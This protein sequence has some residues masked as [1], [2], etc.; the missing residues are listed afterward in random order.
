MATVIGLCG[1]IG[2]GKTTV[3]NYLV[4]EYGF[5][6]RALAK[7]LKD[8]TKIIFQLSDSQ[9]KD[10]E[11]R[12]VVDPRWDKTPRQLMQLFGTEVG[13]SIDKNVW[14]K[15]L[16]SWVDS[17]PDNAFVVV[18]DVRFLNEAKTIKERGGVV[19][20]VRREKCIPPTQ[21]GDVFPSVV[22]KTLRLPRTHESEKQMRNYFHKMTDYVI[23]NET[24]LNKLYDRV[25]FTLSQLVMEGKIEKLDAMRGLK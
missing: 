12:K 21:L 25:D 5:H 19:L 14:V 8:C 18:D 11:L 20:G 2:S 6:K 7:P 17:L 13:R 23:S 15:S 10:R 16:F 3:A 22:A 1:F 4:E 24:S 9:I